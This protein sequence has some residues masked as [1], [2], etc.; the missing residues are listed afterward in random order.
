MRQVLHAAALIG[1]LA[2]SVAACADNLVYVDTRGDNLLKTDADYLSKVVGAER[3]AIVAIVRKRDGKTVKLV[4][5]VRGPLSNS[6]CEALLQPILAD[7]G[8]LGSRKFTLSVNIKGDKHR[9]EVKYAVVCG[10]LCGSGQSRLFDREGD[11]WKYLYS[12]DH[13]I[14]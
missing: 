12:Y 7:M 5:Q 9:V 11:E 14:S 8:A 3:R 13:W 10:L 4:V 2:V 1:F 6:D